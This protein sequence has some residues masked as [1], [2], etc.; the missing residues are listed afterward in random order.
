MRIEDDNG[1]SELL[2]GEESRLC[3]GFGFIEGPIWIA[4]DNALVFATSP[5]T[6]SIAGVRDRVRLRSTASRAAGRMV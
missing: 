2:I 5:A 1:I 3:S 4:S 6:D